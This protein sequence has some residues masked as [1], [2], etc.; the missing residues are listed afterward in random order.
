M[1]PEVIVTVALAD[2]AFT[3]AWAASLENSINSRSMSV[4]YITHKVL[5]AWC[6]ALG[7]PGRRSS[8][9]TSESVT[10]SAIVAITHR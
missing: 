3:N 1:F 4:E 2:P 10:R 9:T 8:A 6:L 5:K 7:K